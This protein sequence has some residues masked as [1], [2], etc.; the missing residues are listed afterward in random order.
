MRPV[1]RTA[2]TV[3]I[4]LDLEQHPCRP[5]IEARSNNNLF[6]HVKSNSSAFI[7]SIDLPITMST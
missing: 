5:K 7:G 6:R 4:M 2:E 1:V 3:A